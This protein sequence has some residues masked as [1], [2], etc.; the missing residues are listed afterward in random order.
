MAAR[1]VR[2]LNVPNLPHPLYEVT[3]PIISRRSA[4]VSIVLEADVRVVDGS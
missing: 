4:M 3:E 2:E 1:I